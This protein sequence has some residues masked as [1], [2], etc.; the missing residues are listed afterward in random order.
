MHDC[1]QWGIFW[2]LLYGEG[3]SLLINETYTGMKS[4]SDTGKPHLLSKLD[5]NS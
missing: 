5:S 3:E 2:G 1:V 4:I